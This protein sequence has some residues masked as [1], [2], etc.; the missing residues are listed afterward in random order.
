[1]MCQGAVGNLPGDDAFT[2]CDVVEDFVIEASGPVIV[3]QFVTS[4]WEAVGYS[5]NAQPAGDPAFILLPPVEQ[6]RSEYIFLVPDDYAFD[7][8][9]IA[10]PSD[11]RV[12]LDGSPIDDF[13]Q[14]TRKLIA[15]LPVEGQEVDF[16]SIVCSLSDPIVSMEGARVVVDEGDQS[17]DG[18]HRLTSDRPVGLTVY[19]FDAFVSYGYPG[20]TDLR[21]INVQ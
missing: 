4:Q 19:G 15:P 12:F 18:V 1:M 5:N 6:Y 7:Y 8:L 13:P 20:G 21:A 16:S 10:A 14:C 3:G 11:A 17:N 9:M 2:M